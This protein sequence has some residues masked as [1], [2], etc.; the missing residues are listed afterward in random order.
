VGVA[1]GA[2]HHHV[3]P[4]VRHGEGPGEQRHHGLD[5]PGGGVLFGD[6]EVALV[7]ARPD[8]FLERGDHVE[9][10]RLESDPATQQLVD[11]VEGESG[12]S[13]G[14]SGEHAEASPVEGIGGGVVAVHEVLPA[15]SCAA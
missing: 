2:G 15:G 10:H 1:L 9:Q 4:V 14:D 7:P 5:R 8:L 3:G 6:A 11:Q 12:I 13:V